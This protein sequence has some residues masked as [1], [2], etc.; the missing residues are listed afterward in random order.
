MPQQPEAKFKHA[1]TEAFEI[2]S[3]TGFHAYTKALGQNGLP[4]L[5]FAVAGLGGAWVEVKVGKNG[6]SKIQARCVD[7]MRAAGEVVVVLSF[8]NPTCTDKKAHIFTVRRGHAAL[9][10]VFVGREALR[11]TSFWAC[12]L[13]GVLP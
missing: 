12:I 1:L 2:V 11:S 5:R 7:R 10:A 4:D 9:P 6:L 3:P 13:S 8:D